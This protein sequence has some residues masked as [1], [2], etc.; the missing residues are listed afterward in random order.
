MSQLTLNNSH[1][2]DFSLRKFKNYEK[3]YFSRDDWNYWLLY[4]ILVLANPMQCNAIDGCFKSKRYS[5]LERYDQQ[6]FV[7]NQTIR[8]IIFNAKTFVECKGLRAK[9]FLRRSSFQDVLASIWESVR[10]R[11][12]HVSLP[13]DNFK[14][15]R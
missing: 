10:V 1:K 6:N 8:M 15:A 3:F 7:L 4:V 11:V 13:A 2:L 5:I 12:R 14:I 9:S